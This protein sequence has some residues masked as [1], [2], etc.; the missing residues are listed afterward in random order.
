MKRRDFNKLALATPLLGLTTPALSK[1]KTY[2]AG[3]LIEYGETDQ[4]ETD[5]Y[6]FLHRRCLTKGDV[7]LKTPFLPRIEKITHYRE[8][9]Y[10]DLYN[11]CLAQNLGIFVEGKARPISTGY[12]SPEILSKAELLPNGKLIGSF[13]VVNRRF[14]FN[15]LCKNGDTKF[16]WNITNG[17]GD[18]FTVSFEIDNW[19]IENYGAQGN[20]TKTLT[21]E[22]YL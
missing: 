15:D 17:I 12:F 8:N 5:Q 7:N 4:Y 16:I 9:I 3:K 22:D 6:G 2:N 21:K 1:E 13:H 19:E 11:R 10:I 14:T 20:L 18:P